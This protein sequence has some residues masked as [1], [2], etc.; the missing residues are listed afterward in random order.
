MLRPTVTLELTLSDGSVRTVE[1]DV[2]MFH[3]LRFSVARALQGMIVAEQ[4]DGL[5]RVI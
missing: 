2:A 3:A 1:L 5:R 4:N